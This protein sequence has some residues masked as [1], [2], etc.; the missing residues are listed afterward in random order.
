MPTPG[1]LVGQPAFNSDGSIIVFAVPKNIKRHGVKF[2]LNRLNG[3][4]TITGDEIKCI[5]TGYSN[6]RSPRVVDGE[7]YFLTVEDGTPHFSASRLVK[8]G[9]EK[10]TVVVDFKCEPEGFPGL[11]LDILPTSLEFGGF[12]YCTSTVKTYNRIIRVELSTGNVTVLQQ[13]LPLFN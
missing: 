5:S 7:V 12:L 6:A 4:Y 10:D 2:C 3:V 9:K 13:G 11:F 8:V 1:L